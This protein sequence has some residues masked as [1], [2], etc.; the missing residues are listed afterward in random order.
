MK[1]DLYKTFSLCQDWSPVLIINDH[2]GAHVCMQEQR[3]NMC[4]QLG[5]VN[6]PSYL[7]QMKSDLHKKFSV[8]Q[9][10]SPQLICNIRRHAHAFMHAQ[11]MKMCRQLK[12]INKPS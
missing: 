9:G 4:T 8:C 1:S 11:H 6:K 7:S 10:W 12:A 5:T 3:V 2:E